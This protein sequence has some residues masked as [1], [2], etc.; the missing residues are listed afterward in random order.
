MPS[1]SA[2]AAISDERASATTAG[3][4]QVSYAAA[5][6]AMSSATST[7]D[8]ACRRHAERPLQARI[9]LLFR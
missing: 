2:R 5:E 1:L 6:G 8:E 9:A 3:L 7:R 4:R